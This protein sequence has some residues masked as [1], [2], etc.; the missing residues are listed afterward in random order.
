MSTKT[1][2]FHGYAGLA[3]II[4]AE[5]LLFRG[6]QL[7]GHWLIVHKFSLKPLALPYNGW[8]FQTTWKRDKKLRSPFRLNLI[9]CGTS[10]QT[11]NWPVVE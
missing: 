7:V 1:F 11:R 3:A 8:M 2:P 9:S 4:A 6:N 10:K 5:A